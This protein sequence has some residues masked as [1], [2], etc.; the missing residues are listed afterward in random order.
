MR[1][2]LRGRRIYISRMTTIKLHLA[3][4]DAGQRPERGVVDTTLP[5]LGGLRG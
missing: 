5:K 1:K 4:V 3:S 2:L